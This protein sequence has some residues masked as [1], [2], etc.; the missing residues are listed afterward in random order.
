MANLATLRSQIRQ[1]AD[2]DASD[3]SDAEVNTYINDAYQEAL[4][5][6][7]WPFLIARAT[8]NTVNAQSDYTA[9][10]MALTDLEMPRLLAVMSAGVDLEELQP[11]HYFQLQPYGASPSTA[12]TSL[13]HY[14]ILE[15]TKLVLWPTPSAAQ[16]VQIVYV[17]LASD[18]TDDANIPV[19]PSRY[20]FVLKWGGLKYLYLKIGDT[21][22]AT[23]VG[24]K[25]SDGIDLLV[26]DL[27]KAPSVTPLIWGRRQQLFDRSQRLRYP[28]E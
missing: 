11:Q 13:L 19:F 20:H 25:F 5:N 27:L 23:D 14:T 15:G 18:L 17:K 1:L 3:V 16:A 28:W 12:S 2:V 22:S 4:G 7:P 21:D 8:F 10:D 6:D 26:Q 9:T 24:K